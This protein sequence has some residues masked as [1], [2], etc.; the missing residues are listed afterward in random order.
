MCT[1]AASVAGLAGFCAVFVGVKMGRAVLSDGTSV[2]G[3]AGCCSVFVDVKM[4]RAELSDG[5]GISVSAW[6]VCKSVVGLVSLHCWFQRK[7]LCSS[8]D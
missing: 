2:A 4:G 3:L 5:A 6:L 8:L 1:A 7:T